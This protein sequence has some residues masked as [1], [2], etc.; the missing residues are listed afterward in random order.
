MITS[1][2]F[3]IETSSLYPEFGVV[4][5][6]VI[7]P[8]KGKLKVYRA[9]ELNK[10]WKTR[11]SNDLEIV[12]QICDEL[13]KYDI[14]IAHNGQKFDIPFLRSRMSYW[15]L[16]QFPNKKVIDPY[17]IARNKYRLSSNSLAALSEFFQTKVKKSS[18]P[19][20]IWVKAALD[21][22]KKAMD[23]IVDHCKRDVL[24]LAELIDIVKA[25]SSVFNQSGSGW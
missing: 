4:L 1:C 16:G 10:D 25:Y 5:V 18:V 21:G 14:L 6:G 2:C 7:K 15:N 13:S 19:G 17:Q 22:D 20:H 24:A 23:Y 9:D 8:D 12:K 3:D 11:R